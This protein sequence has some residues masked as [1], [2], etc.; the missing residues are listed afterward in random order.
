MDYGTGRFGWG[1]FEVEG[2]FAGFFAGKVEDWESGELGFGGERK[3][4]GF[5]ERE[6]EGGFER[7]LVGF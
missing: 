5:G 2:S 6:F 1:G 7:E 4:W 3:L